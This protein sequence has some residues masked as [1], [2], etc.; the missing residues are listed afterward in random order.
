MQKGK[1]SQF[2]TENEKRFTDKKDDSTKPME[3]QILDELYKHTFS[4]KKSD[5][6]V[7]D[8]EV[9]ISDGSADSRK[10]CDMVLLHKREKKIMFVEG[11]IADDRRMATKDLINDP[12][13][14][15]K[16][17]NGYTQLIANNGDSIIAAYE[18][19]ISIINELFKTN[20]P[21]TIQSII[22]GAKLLVYG[23]ANTAN[24]IKSKELILKELGS[25]NVLWYPGSS[26]DLSLNDIW[27]KLS[28]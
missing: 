9:C 27:D 2:F 23:E 16:Q 26:K 22:S 5:V 19:H 14:V 10:K 12:P 28:P 1:F 4:E 24:C 25:K 18:N 6:I 7:L 17:V 8:I 3:R 13:E 20:F 21:E 15:I 11:K